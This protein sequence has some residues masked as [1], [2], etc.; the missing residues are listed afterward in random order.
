MIKIIKHR[1]YW[2]LFSST[3]IVLSL[4]VWIAFGL[5]PGIDFTGGTLLE[6]EYKGGARPA[7]TEIIATLADL[8]LGLS[9]SA[10]G[11]D[12]YALR[13]KEVSKEQH[14]QIFEKLKAATPQG[15]EV[16]ET[17]FTAIG[18][19][20]GQEL[21][22]R[23][24]EAIA[25]VLIAIMLYIAYSFRKV[26]YPVASWKYGLVA[27]IAL[28][29]DII[30]TVGITVLLGKYLGWEINT[31]FVAALLTILGYSI[32]DTIVIFDRIRETLTR[33]EG[34]FAEIAEKALS[35]TIVRSFNTS[36]TTILALVA[37]FFFGGDSVRPF[38]TTLIVGIIVGTYSSI[39]VAAPLLVTWQQLSWKLKKN[40]E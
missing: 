19:V 7:Q 21:K 26:S 13:F 27:L 25:L 24:V 15:S 6:V 20:V 23:S 17:Q 16:V 5:K 38:V 12:G 33:Y 32:S 40:K 35:E 1:K 22:G 11:E 37:I 31:P 10:L 36:M 2:F 30:F 8:N 18:P 39:F 34:S 3:L 4:L 14:Q 28:C 29:H 9:V